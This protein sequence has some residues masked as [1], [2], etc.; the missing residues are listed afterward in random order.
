MAAAAPDGVAVLGLGGSAPVV[1]GLATR[2]DDD[3][4]L[5]T[6]FRIAARAAVPSL[7]DLLPTARPAEL[8]PVG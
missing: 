2:D 1:A 7:L 5:V 4:P 6:A 8:E 3:R